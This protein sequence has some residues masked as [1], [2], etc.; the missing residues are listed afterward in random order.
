[1]AMILDWVAVNARRTAAS[2]ALSACRLTML[3]MTCRL[4]A[5][6]FAKL[7]QQGFFLGEGAHVAHA[8]FLKGARHLVE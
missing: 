5:T 1:M 2:D 4:L 3:D 6:R 7:L 8:A